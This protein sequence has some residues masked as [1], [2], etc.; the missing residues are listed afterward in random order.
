MRNGGG[1]HGVAGDLNVGLA[2]IP[3]QDGAGKPGIVGSGGGR[4]GGGVGVGGVGV[5]IKEISV[6]VVRLAK[7]GAVEPGGGAVV[8]GG[9]PVGE[10]IAKNGR[11]IRQL[12]V[13]EMLES[14]F[15]R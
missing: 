12:T 5:Q 13:G 3:V 14:H 9:L 15:L 10:D 1:D 2:D 7:N 4:G 11:I 6:E 8:V